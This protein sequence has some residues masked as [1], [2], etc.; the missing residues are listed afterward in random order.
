MM[1]FYCS[2]QPLFLGSKIVAAMDTAIHEDD[3]ETV[4]MIQELLETRIRPV[5]QDDGRDNEYRGFDPDTK[6]VKLKLQRGCSGCPSSSVTLKFS[7]ENML[8]HYV[9]EVITNGCAYTL[10]RMY[11]VRRWMERLG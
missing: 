1:D 7:I 5:V 3:S 2:G 8:M 9:P 11:L 6:K 10:F 4:A